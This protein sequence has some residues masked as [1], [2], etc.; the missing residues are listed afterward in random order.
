FARAIAAYLRGFQNHYGVSFYS[1]SIQNELTFE[2]FY[3]SATY[4]LA[5][6]YIAALRAVRAEL[7]RYPDLASIRIMGPEDLMGGDPYALW[8]YG[9]GTGVTHKNLQFLAAIAA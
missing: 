8:Q 6:Q 7:D 3:N 2:E 1:I 4:P 9:S 5:S